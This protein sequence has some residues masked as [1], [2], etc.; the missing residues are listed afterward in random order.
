MP[1][2]V[3]DSFDPVWGTAAN[4]DEV[5]DGIREMVVVLTALLND[6]PPCYILNVVRESNSEPI[7]AAG[8]LCERQLRIL[9]YACRVA[10]EEEDL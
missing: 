7:P 2:P 9:R 6:A 3:S 4:A 10:L 5:R 8:M 1:G